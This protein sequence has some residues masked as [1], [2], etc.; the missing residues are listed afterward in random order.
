MRL[1][2]VALPLV[3]AA[4]L[5]SRESTASSQA[6]GDARPAATP[7][8]LSAPSSQTWERIVDSLIGE[9]MNKDELVRAH[10]GLDR[11]G[12]FLPRERPELRTRLEQLDSAQRDAVERVS[13]D[14]RDALL[15]LARNAMDELQIALAA[16][17]EVGALEVAP[18]DAQQVASAQVEARA[19]R[20]KTT[21][22]YS[23]SFT[24][25]GWLVSVTLD[26]HTSPQFAQA[27]HEFSSA[28]QAHDEDV[29]RFLGTL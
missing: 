17:I 28:R 4:A 26:S 25:D 7:A 6:I 20:R 18:L 22:A 16:A 9:G 13:R 21:A 3:A 14:H 19:Q 23:T 29:L 8:A 15:A 11:A 27:L 5:W 10:C 2:L 1:L 24:V 12:L